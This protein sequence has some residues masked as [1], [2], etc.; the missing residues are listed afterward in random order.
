MALLS[1]PTLR[2]GSLRGEPTL[3]AGLK[4]SDPA[5]VKQAL[6][7]G[8]VVDRWTIRSL[9]GSGTDSTLYLAQSGTGRR[10]TVLKVHPDSTGAPPVL[11]Q[12]RDP[13]LMPLLGCGNW[14]GHA[15]EAMPLYTDGTLAEGPLPESVLVQVV[16]PQ[17]DQALTALHSV[18]LLHNDVKPANLFWAKRREQ[19]VLG[20]YD[21][22]RSETD[23][24]PA[25]GTPAYMAPETLFSDGQERSEAS[26]YCSMGLTLLALLTGQSPLA[27]QSRQAMERAWQQGIP[28]PPTVSPRLSI[29]IQ[30]LLRYDPAQRMQH[31]QVQH[32]LQQYGRKSVTVP[33]S[34]PREKA[35]EIF[36][37]TFKDRVLLDPRELAAAA[38]EDWMYTQFLLRQHQ[39]DNFLIQFNKDYYA[40]CQTCAGTFD[41]DEGLFRLLR[42]LCPGKA[43]CWCG[44]EYAGLEEMVQQAL[45]RSP[46][47]RDDPAVRFLKLGMLEVYL[48]STGATKE[49]KAFAASLEQL[50]AEDPDLAM[51]QL[52]IALGRQPEFCWHG[53]TFH[54]LAD[55]TGW[56]LSR[57]DALDGA[58]QELYGSKRLEAWLDFIGQG[59]FLP[60]IRQ[61]G[62]GT[63]P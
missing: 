1:Q 32:W 63:Q 7:E 25:G 24:Q 60:E 36:P 23:R 4:P 11:M 18:H 26:D 35:P 16:I 55:L 41:G 10:D 28:C 56:L 59:R 61:M 44:R 50:A 49:Q 39:L 14:Q 51:A 6:P 17:L 21:W 29:L 42:A 27:G 43:L 48:D 58:V 38:G 5:Q 52:M 54:S 31:Q 15:Y 19:L 30:G 40:L 12:L 37:L 45:A 8:T 13:C 22:V 33:V 20:D 47:R 46:L 53:A 62:K 57:T 9:L 2:P 34:R 3:P